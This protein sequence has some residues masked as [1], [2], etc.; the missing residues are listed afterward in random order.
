[1]TREEQL[2]EAFIAGMFDEIE[3]QASWY[4]VARQAWRAGKA[5]KAKD[6]GKLKKH[7]KATWLGAKAHLK[8]DITKAQGRR[9]VAGRS[10]AKFYPTIGAAKKPK[11]KSPI[12]P[13]TEAPRRSNVKKEWA[14]IGGFV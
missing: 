5:F 6:I 1:M 8:R 3:K 10:A 11:V 2:R 14:D 7:L 4:G 9:G 12:Y 13:S